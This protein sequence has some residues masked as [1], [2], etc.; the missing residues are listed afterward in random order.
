V[1]EHPDLALRGLYFALAESYL[2]P[3]PPEIRNTD[4]EVLEPRTLYFDIESAQSAFDALASLAI[5]TSRDELLED[6]KF[7]V[8]GAVIEALIPTGSVQRPRSIVQ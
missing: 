3:P 8:N 6:A 1:R 2:H 7:D 5:G 4:G